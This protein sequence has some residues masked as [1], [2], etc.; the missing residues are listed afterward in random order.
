[1]ATR[2]VRRDSVVHE[3]VPVLTA[4]ELTL[5]VVDPLRLEDLG[6]L[7]PLEDAL[8]PRQGLGEFLPDPLVAALGQVLWR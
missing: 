8:D 3:P 1:M 2:D 7:V 6:H 5:D 4:V